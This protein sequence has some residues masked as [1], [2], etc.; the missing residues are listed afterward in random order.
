MTT[1]ELPDINI[2]MTTYRDEETGGVYW[3]TAWKFIHN[4]NSYGD[5]MLF[6][7]NHFNQGE[8]LKV[9]TDTLIEQ[10]TNTYKLLIKE[11]K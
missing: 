6:D 10:A 4:E 8:C 2:Y 9:A 1:E 11:L 3:C 5:Y 7:K